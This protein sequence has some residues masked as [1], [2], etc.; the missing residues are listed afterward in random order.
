MPELPEVETIVRQLRNTVARHTIFSVD[1]FRLDYLRGQPMEFFTRG[2]AGNTIIWIRRRGKFLIFDLSRGKMLA[3]LGMTGKFIIS[4]FKSNLPKHTVARFR[5]EFNDLLLIDQR[6]FGRLGYY[7]PGEMPFPLARLGVEPLEAKFTAEYLQKRL[8][9]RK[10]AIKELLL[11]QNIIA[12]LGNIYTNEILFRAGVNPAIKGGKL[13]IER[14][15]R[16]VSATERVLLE[17]IERNGTTISNY[18]QVDDKAGDFQNF[19]RVYG[20]AGENCPDCGTGIVRAVIGGRSSF[21]CPKCQ[22]L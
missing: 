5:L 22:P 12:G 6:R 18:R 13:T 10:R 19:L 8:Q 1:V 2:V 21:F 15:R 4:P 11:D 7:A 9:G 17:A 3:H 14:L 20:K 16:I